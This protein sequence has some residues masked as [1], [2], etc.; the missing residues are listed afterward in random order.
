M[1][2]DFTRAVLGVPGINYGVLL[3]RSSD[4]ASFSAIFNPAY[5][6]ESERPLALSL[7]QHAVGPR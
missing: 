3:T 1:A 4:W 6:R 5:P 7:D 2:P